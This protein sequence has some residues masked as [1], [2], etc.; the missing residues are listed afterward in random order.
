MRRSKG[1]W[2]SSGVEGA[3]IVE[4]EKEGG[5]DNVPIIHATRLG[6]GGESSCNRSVYDY[7]EPQGLQ[8]YLLVLILLLLPSAMSSPQKPLIEPAESQSATS[9]NSSSSS[10]GKMALSNQ[11]MKVV[12]LVV[13]TFQNAI[14]S[15]C[16]RMATTAGGEKGAIQ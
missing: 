1:I 11:G 6:R 2:G 7:V 9:S 15:F 3:R 13:L 5:G 8:Y 14:L 10:S 16:M 12:S 4:E